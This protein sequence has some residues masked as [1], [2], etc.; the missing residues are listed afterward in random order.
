MSWKRSI[1]SAVVAIVICELAGAAGALLGN[2]GIKRWYPTLRKPT[3][4]PPSWVFG[5]VWTLLYGCM[6]V[7][8]SVVWRRRS[9]EKRAAA[10]LFVFAFQLVA[11]VLWTFAFFN[12]RSTGA[13][14]TVIVPL[15]LLITLTIVLFWPIAVLAALLMVP[16]LLWVSFA[17]ALNLCVWQLNRD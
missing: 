5:P 9:D 4:T 1:G 13:G 12:R 14:L 10:A 3:F 6:G 8:V 15:W 17:T 11:N 16:Y 2:D 7:A